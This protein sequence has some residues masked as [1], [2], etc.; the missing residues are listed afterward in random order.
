MRERKRTVK[1]SIKNRKEYVEVGKEKG[2][3]EKEV[4]VLRLVAI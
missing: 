1:N 4:E 3:L 2:R